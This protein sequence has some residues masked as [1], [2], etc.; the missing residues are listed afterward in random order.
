MRA[1]VF[2]GENPRLREAD[3]PDPAPG[4][5]E[6]L[7]DVRACGVCRTDLH[8]VDGDL[9]Q[10]KRPVIPGHEIVGTICELTMP[11]FLKNHTRSH[12]NRQPYSTP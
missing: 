3:L 5:G 2:D 11:S 12:R 4:E 7:I 8:V 6:L 10:P 9:A 1:M